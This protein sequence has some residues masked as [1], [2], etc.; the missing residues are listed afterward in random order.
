MADAKKYTNKLEGK[1]ILVIGGTSGIGYAVAEASVEYGADVTV[2]SSST[3]KVQKTI[4]SLIKAYPSAK[5]RVHGFACDLSTPELDGN[6]KK[7]LE[8]TTAAAG[9]KLDHI[10]YTAG[11]SL[12]QTGLESATLPLLQKAAMVRFNGP[13]F[14]GKHAPQFMTPG[15]ASSITL[16]NGVVSQKPNKGWSLIAGYSAGLPGMARNLSLDIAPLRV[17]VVE[18]GA[19]LTELWDSFT[20]SPEHRGQM[21]EMFK[22]KTTTGQVGA[23]A[24]LAEAYLYVFR[25]PNVTGTVIAS[26]GGILLV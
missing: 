24:D 1:R 5:S 6:I 7:L 9:G 10:A 20:T 21:I 23:P 15:P 12:T 4:D 17:N 16:T 8:D 19:V 11:D 14:V 3:A 26:N 2:S 18:P 25:N 22:G 13:L